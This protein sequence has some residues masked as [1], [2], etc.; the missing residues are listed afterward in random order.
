[1][2]RRALAGL[3][4]AGL[5]AGP[6]LVPANGHAQEGK[7]VPPPLLRIRPLMVPVVQSGAVRRYV[8]VEVALE[9]A[10]P[11]ALPEAQ[12]KLAHLQDATLQTLYDAVDAG[13][14]DR[15]TIVDMTALRRRI[16]EESERL[17]GAGAVVRVAILPLARQGS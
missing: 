5:S 4:L 7:A 16:D 9:L 8:I 3:L 6:L 10:N 1:M 14:I 13:W 11:L 2:R 15:G 12:G 17:L